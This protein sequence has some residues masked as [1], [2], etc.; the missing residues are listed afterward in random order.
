MYDTQK[1]DNKDTHGE[2]TRTHSGPTTH[3]ETPGMG[4]AHH[5]QQPPHPPEACREA[6]EA[7]T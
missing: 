2:H 7:Q 4:I 6:T 1:A 3:T 5:T